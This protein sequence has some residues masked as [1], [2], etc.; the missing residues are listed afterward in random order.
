M[1]KVLFKTSYNDI[2]P[3]HA[4]RAGVPPDFLKEVW[5]RLKIASAM[6]NANIAVMRETCGNV[7]LIPLIEFCSLSH[8]PQINV[9]VVGRT[10][11]AATGGTFFT[12]RT[13]HHYTMFLKE[14]LSLVRSLDRLE[15]GSLQEHLDEKRCGSVTKLWNDNSNLRHL[16]IDYA[17]SYMKD[18]F[19][20]EPDFVE[21]MKALCVGIQ[22]DK[23]LA[24]DI[25]A[26]MVHF[27]CILVKL[28]LG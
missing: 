28:Y 19:R 23:E 7:C 5:H 9:C 8:V 12:Y 16:L 6:R 11:L 21:L 15:M 10:A 27:P 13:G 18:E 2:L 3:Y 14:I 25:G 20:D 1:P 17:T 26:S 24:H 4:N 22:E